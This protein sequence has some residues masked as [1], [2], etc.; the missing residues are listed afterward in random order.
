MD[1][2]NEVKTYQRDRW[3]ISIRSKPLDGSGLYWG[4]VD[5]F[6]DGERLC[7]LAS[8]RSFASVDDLIAAQEAKANKWI[9]DWQ[10]RPHDGTTGFGEV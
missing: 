1:G 10:Q 3:R 2:D 8:V 9:E 6:R 7:R 4:S 5:V